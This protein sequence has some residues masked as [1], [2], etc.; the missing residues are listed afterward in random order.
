M[1][2][3]EVEGLTAPFCVY[4]V[5]KKLNKINGIENLKNRFLESDCFSNI[6]KYT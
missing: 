2:K 6:N 3:T 5:E 4:D 1:S